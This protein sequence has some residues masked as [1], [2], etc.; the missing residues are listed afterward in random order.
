MVGRDH[1]LTFPTRFSQRGRPRKFIQPH[2]NG[3]YEL[4]QHRQK[5]TLKEQSLTGTLASLLLHDNV[6]AIEDI[7]LCQQIYLLRRRYLGLMTN[8]IDGKSYF[9]STLHCVFSKSAPF[10]QH[11]SGTQ[12][13]NKGVERRWKNLRLK[14]FHHATLH[15]MDQLFALVPYENMAAER[16]RFY[17]HYPKHMI[18]SFVHTLVHLAKDTQ[19]D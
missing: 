3:T 10:N 5:V 7:V 8:N 11:T 16:T 17:K 19:Q 15:F 9:P 18:R 13:E 6:I 12:R 1:I 14:G 4:Q 2:D